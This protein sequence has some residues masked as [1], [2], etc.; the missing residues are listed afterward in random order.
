[1]QLLNKLLKVCGKHHLKVWAEGGTLLG[2]IR[3]KG[4]IPWDDDIDMAMMRDDYDKLQ[5]VAK[6]EFKAPFFP[7]RVY[8]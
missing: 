5:S 4:F 6:E 1:M 3:D 8:R 2:T 7:V